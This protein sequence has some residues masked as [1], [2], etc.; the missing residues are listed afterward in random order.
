MRGSKFE[1]VIKNMMLYYLFYLVIILSF[2]I[3]KKFLFGKFIF[4]FFLLFFIIMYY[5]WL[6]WFIYLS[7]LL[8][9][10][11]L[12]L[13]LKLKERYYDVENKVKVSIR[14]RKVY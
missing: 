7:C 10:Y 1:F 14:I 8:K 4:D 3:I 13:K 5:L 12:C 9:F 11:F 6:V 2:F